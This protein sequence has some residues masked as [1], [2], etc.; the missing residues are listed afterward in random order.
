MK[1]PNSSPRVVVT[2]S[3]RHRLAVRIGQLKQAFESGI[4]S[5]Q[6]YMENLGMMPLQDNPKDAEYRSLVDKVT[7]MMTDPHLAPYI[8]GPTTTNTKV[9]GQSVNETTLQINAAEMKAAK[10]NVDKDGAYEE[11]NRLVALLARL[12]PSGVA[13]DVTSPDWYIVYIDLPMG[14]ASWHIPNAEIGL[15]EGIPL[16]QGKWDNHTTDEKY[17]RIERLTKVLSGF[18]VAITPKGGLPEDPP[19]DFP[20]E[21]DETVKVSW[22]D[23]ADKAVKKTYVNP[24]RRGN[25]Q[26][27]SSAMV[28]PGQTFSF[29]QPVVLQKLHISLSP[30]SGPNGVGAMVEVMYEDA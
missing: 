30:A 29:E 3:P 23:M 28:A 17:K 18:D 22:V 16:Y 27:I 15:F 24:P 4:I 19:A 21:I 14:Q 11:R 26:M 6:S 12:F 20:A 7:A 9:M 2:T 10:A 25:T 13:P 1:S 8:G 5:N